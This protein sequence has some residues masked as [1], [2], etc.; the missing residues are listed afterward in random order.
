MPNTD[1]DRHRTLVELSMWLLATSLLTAF[2]NI[3]RQYLSLALNNSTLPN[4]QIVFETLA[5][6]NYRNSQLSKTLFFVNPHY[7]I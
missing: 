6:L 1:R 3:F 7:T 4:V 5:I 2:T